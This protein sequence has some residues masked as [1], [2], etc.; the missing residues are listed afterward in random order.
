M[1]RNIASIL[2]VAAILAAVLGCGK[3]EEEKK[4]DAAKADRGPKFYKARLELAKKPAKTVLVQEPFIK[5]TVVVLTTTDGSEPVY[6]PY[7]PMEFRSFEANSPEELGT[8][9][10]EEC[11]SFQKGVY[12]TQENPPREVPAMAIDCD[13]SLIDRQAGAVYFTKRFEGK[14][15]E[16]ASISQSSNTVYKGPNDEI[17]KWLG[18]LPRK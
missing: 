4:A 7:P 12:R 2:A 6:A 3:S 1:K 5:G 18:A 11:K 9:V 17:N 16:Q 14:L 13:V 15:N 8:V 10:L